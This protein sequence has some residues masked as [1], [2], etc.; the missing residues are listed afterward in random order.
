M[1]ISKVQEIN[2]IIPTAKIAKIDNLIPRLCAEEM[3]TL[4]PLTGEEL[5][6]QMNKDYIK[7][8]EKLW[9][10]GVERSPEEK[11]KVNII[12]MAQEVLLYTYLAN[13][14]AI[15]QSSLNMGGGW[16]K[17]S[18]DD[19]DALDDKA[20]TR[21]DRD[22]W[23]SSKRAKENF[24][25]WIEKDATS[26]EV[27]LESWKGSPFYNAQKKLLFAKASDIHPVYADL[28]DFPY[29][30]F[31]KY[32]PVINNCQDGF[33]AGSIGDKLLKE[34]IG[35]RMEKEGRSEEW[36]TLEQHVKLALA[37]F[38]QYEMEGAK[39]EHVR[40]RGEAQ[41]TLARTIILNNYDSFKEFL[42]GTPLYKEEEV[43]ALPKKDKMKKEKK[44]NGTVF[45]LL[46]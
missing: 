40:N 29:L 28:G 31:N 10:E 34:L 2:Y 22:L 17:P 41:L 1:L 12:R 37:N 42:K 33:I 19:Y 43:T 5:L 3:N 25:R 44:N 27:Y 32:V 35:M 13:H 26:T 21:L 38:V 8:S 18:T 20:N 39:N 23:N 30:N 7:M 16:N 6:D 46:N 11:M 4:Y 36:I 45:S 9:E 24:L 14:S 15:L